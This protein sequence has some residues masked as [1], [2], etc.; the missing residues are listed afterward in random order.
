MKKGQEYKHFKGGQYI[1][2]GIT[3]PL[4]ATE[5][6]FEKSHLKRVGRA[7]HSESQESIT[8]FDYFGLPESGGAGLIFSD[9]DVPYVLYQ[10]IKD[11]EGEKL[12]LRQ[13]EDFF[14]YK[15]FGSGEM[16]RRFSLLE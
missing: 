3:I 8:L 4:K 10:N 16:V 15:E 13:V 1:F 12:W 14:G 5:C 9:T 2:L 7:M 11:V 6:S